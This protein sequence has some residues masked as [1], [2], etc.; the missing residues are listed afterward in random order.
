MRPIKLTISAFG[1]YAG[2]SVI[3]MDNLGKD[4]I[5]LITGDTGDEIQTTF[6]QYFKIQ[7]LGPRI[8]TETGNDQL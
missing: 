7:F 2:C 1:P 4:G 8:G 5:Y 6:S 3:D